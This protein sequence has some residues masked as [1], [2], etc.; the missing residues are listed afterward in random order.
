MKSKSRSLASFSAVAL[1]LAA[2]LLAQPALAETYTVTLKSGNEFV[3]KYEP[4]Q[5]WY[6]DQKLLIMTTT[7][8][9]I[10]LQKADID[11]ITSSTEAQGFGVV[12]DT[13]TILVGI[14]A[15]DAPVFDDDTLN[16]AIDRA[17]QLQSLRQAMGVRQVPPASSGSA[18][19][20]LT[21]EPN[22]GGGVPVGFIN[23]VT[24]PIGNINN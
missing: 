8:N 10:A 24:P 14:S 4:R 22:R 11:T 1:V 16:Q 13:T 23:Q 19:V 7:G 12:I 6:S 9:I 2:A 17:T 5:A 18:N 3:T 20:P 21:G 15:N